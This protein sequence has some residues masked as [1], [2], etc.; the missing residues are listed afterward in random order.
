M[1]S[2]TLN[3][4]YLNALTTLEFSP[5]TAERLRG[6]WRTSLHDPQGVHGPRVSDDEMDQLTG[7]SMQVQGAQLLANG[8][9]RAWFHYQASIFERRRIDLLFGPGEVLALSTTTVASNQSGSM[10]E[11]YEQTREEGRRAE[12]ARLQAGF[13]E[14]AQ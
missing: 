4:P 9:V 3:F 1:T 5:A 2:D 12:V 7:N 11:D 6:R 14:S 10:S 13:A 8:W